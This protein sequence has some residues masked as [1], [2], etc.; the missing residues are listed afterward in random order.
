MK[1]IINHGKPPEKPNFIRRFEC[2]NCKCV[3]EADLDEYYTVEPDH[4]ICWHG[5]AIHTKCYSLNG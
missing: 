5:R 2:V 3:F 4:M 1:K